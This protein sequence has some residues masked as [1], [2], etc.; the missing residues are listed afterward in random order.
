MSG[1][2]AASPGRSA[3][4]SRS[5]CPSTA[6]PIVSSP[7]RRHRRG[8]R[9]DRARRTRWSSSTTARPIGPGTSSRPS[10]APTPRSSGIDLRQNFGQDNAILTGLRLA[11]GRAVAIMDD[12]LQHDPAD[13][14]APAG[15]AR[16][17]GPTSSTPTSGVKHQAAWK[18]LGSWF[19]GKVAEWVLDKPPGVYLSPY[20]V[21]RREVAEL[22][23]RYD[24]PGALRRRPA[25][26]GDVAVRPGA[27]RAPPALRRAEQLQP[28]AVDRRLGAAGDRFLGPAAPAGDLVR[29]GPRDPGRAAR[30]GRGRR[31]GC[32][33]RE[34]FAGGRRGL[35][36]ADGRR[37]SSSAAC[38]WSSSACSG[39]YVGRMHTAVAGKKPQATVREVLNAGPPTPRPRSRARRGVRLREV[40]LG[41]EPGLPQAARLRAGDARPLR[42]P[43]RRAVPGGR[44]PDPGGFE[45][46]WTSA[47]AR[48][49]S[50]IATSAAKAVDY[51]GLDLNARFVARV[52]RR[53]GRGCVWDLHDDRPLPEADIVVMQASL[54]QFLPDPAP[55]VRR[56]L[57]AAR[58]R[59]IIAEPV[60]NLVDS[61]VPLA[62]RA[63]RRQT[64]PGSATRPRRFDEPTL[65]AFVASLGRRR[66]GRRSSS[67]GGVRRSTSSTSGPPSTVWPGDPPPGPS[68]ER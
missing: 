9:A 60:R 33:T 57:A 22:I 58:E 48:A 40:S 3:R 6:A 62:R 23:C 30:R 7:R 43:L 54:Y 67:P 64:D 11:R 41:P 47:A 63:G 61:R 35:G 34:R 14:P 29:A 24:G 12:D 65:D 51:T 38:R 49:S 26:P 2:R 42:P 27:G 17:R 50:S 4:A 21:I 55:V 53:G 66:P 20:K 46:R 39:E 28:R 8:A 13:L 59:V 1:S 52:E 56:M 10:A 16:R 18:N 32:S 68:P 37:S 5:S 36:L 44:R 19:N 31:T 15:E 45:R 25:L